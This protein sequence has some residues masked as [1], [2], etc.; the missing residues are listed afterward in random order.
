MVA[1]V[2]GRRVSGTSARFLLS[3][4]RPRLA[5]AVARPFATAPAA[6]DGDDDGHYAY[7]T[8]AIILAAGLGTRLRPFTEE[9]PK[10]FVPVAG[11][12]MVEHTAAALQRSGVD[13]FVVVR[14]Y[15]GEVFD[16]PASQAFFAPSNLEL[17]TNEHYESTEVLQSLLVSREKW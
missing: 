5:T 14:G 17:V 2:I 10:C 13:D 3:G 15:K 8:Q 11:K 6:V 4:A 16:T 7:P 1:Q 9:Q 12:P